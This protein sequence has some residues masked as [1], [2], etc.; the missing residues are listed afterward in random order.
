[1]EPKLIKVDKNG[2]KY[3]EGYDKCWKCGG[4]GWYYWG[5]VINGS[6]QYGGVCFA[7]GGSGKTFQS[8]KEYTPEYQRKLD[9]RRRKSHA[10]QW[11]A[12]R[13]SV[14]AKKGFNAEGK[15]Y[16]VLGE[17]Y[18]IKDAIKAEG[19]R[20]NNILGWYFTSP[21]DAF[22]TVEIDWTDLLVEN[23]PT[24]TSFGGFSYKEGYKDILKAITDEAMPPEEKPTPVTKHIGKEGERLTLTATL[25]SKRY[26]DTVSYNYSTSED[27]Y[28]YTFNDAD[29]NILKWFST[30]SLGKWADKWD[31]N[32][33][34]HQLWANA[35]EGDTLTF[36]A[37]VK[38]HDEYNGLKQ[39]VLTRLIVTSITDKGGKTI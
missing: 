37:T 17:T 15:T 6:P 12:E 20:Y 30:A 19:G 36:K 27:L 1:M 16:K 39:T 8:W 35:E 26:I 10:K 28:L 38:K 29:G 31:D 22:K 9:E 7:C 34:G 4:S 14:L 32:N 25:V 5:A 11:D 33:G 13:Q 24:K 21:T 23:Q 2:T 18:S 3:Y